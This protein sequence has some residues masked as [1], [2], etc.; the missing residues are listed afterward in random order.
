MKVTFTE[1]GLFTGWPNNVVPVHSIQG[2]ADN[3]FYVIGKMISSSIV[4]GGQPPLC[5]AKAVGDYIVY[6]EVKSSP[7]LED[8]HDFS[9][10][11]SLEKV[12]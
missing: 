11:Q 5:F 1:S 3:R 7:C 4:Q 2:V 9:I 10:R 12:S 6:D 8:I